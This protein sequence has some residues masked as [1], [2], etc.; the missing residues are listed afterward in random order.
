MP[1][2]RIPDVKIRS[3]LFPVDFS[4]RCAAVV[5]HVE[6]VARRSGAAVTMLHLV[7][8]LVMKYGP[9]ET[10][11]FADLQPERMVAKAKEMLD[12]FA[13]TAFE[14]VNVRRFVETGDPATGIAGFAQEQ[15]MGL[16]MMPTRGRGPFRAALLGSITAKVLHDA[17][18]PVWTAAHVDTLASGRHLEWRNIVCA[19]NLS[20]RSAGLVQ[21]ARE[22]QESCGATVRIA[23]AVPG[24]EA[25][26]QRLMNAEFE[27]T[28]REQ[29]ELAI[30][31]I[32]EEAGT[33]F[34]VCVDAGEV[35]K[36]IAECVRRQD[37]DLV[38]AGR[39]RNRTTAP[40]RSH[41]YAII[42]DA[43]CPVLSV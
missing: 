11:V 29:S 19:I 8:P 14:G 18:C 12:G 21:T 25:L 40:L 15:E 37:A 26:P 9:V 38:L 5:P 43:A 27:A 31:G 34:G 13:S 3:I 41:T 10:F 36:V 1:E 2:R 39:G 33:N 20:P 23:N 24:E 16:I 22:L 35:S 7:E 17:A 30:Q 42:R 32:Q 4:D 28:L 6:A